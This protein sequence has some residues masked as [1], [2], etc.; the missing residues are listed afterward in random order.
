MRRSLGGSSVYAEAFPLADRLCL[1]EVLDTPAEADAFFP[2]YNSNEW[3][4]TS[5]E[6]H[7]YDDRHAQAYR[8]VDYTRK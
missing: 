2:A 4:V 7:G 8:F 3:K 6:F 1:T 5:L